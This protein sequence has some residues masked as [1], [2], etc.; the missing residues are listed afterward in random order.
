MSA[1]NATIGYHA[2]LLDLLGVTRWVTDIT[3]TQVIT[4]ESYH[5]FD[6]TFETLVDIAPSSVV[7]EGS[8]PV[9]VPSVADVTPSTGTDD[10]SVRAVTTDAIASP[11]PTMAIDDVPKIAYELEGVRVGAW[12]LIADMMLLSQDE[13]SVWASL[14]S[15]LSVWCAEREINFG[16]HRL[17]YPMN[18]ELNHS[19]ALAQKCLDGFVLRL[20]MLGDFSQK[21][22]FLSELCDGV[23]YF[24]ESVSLPTLAQMSQDKQYKKQLWQQITG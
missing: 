15:A 19:Q 7:S 1:S 23:D 16:A 10:V 8:A 12:I 18:D 4:Q 22:A 2:H 3:P 13:R 24:G 5:R 20:Q 11:E 17:G 21:V 6:D 9:A 14:K